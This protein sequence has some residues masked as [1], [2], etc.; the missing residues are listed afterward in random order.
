MSAAD[1]LKPMS[2]EEIQSLRKLAR[3]PQFR[4]KAVEI[5][6][7]MKANR[8]QAQEFLDRRRTELVNAENILAVADRRWREGEA[9]LAEIEA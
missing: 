1:L 4:E 7:L 5:V 2:S 9:L 6:A 3:N 8:D